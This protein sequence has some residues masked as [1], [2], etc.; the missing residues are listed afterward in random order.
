MSLVIPSNVT[1]IG[2]S[3]YFNS[4]ANSK[5]NPVAE[6][7]GN[8]GIISEF[9]KVVNYSTLMAESNPIYIHFQVCLTI[10]STKAD[11]KPANFVNVRSWKPYVKNDQG[12]YEGIAW[13]TVYSTT[14]C[15]YNLICRSFIIRLGVKDEGNKK[16]NFI[17]ANGVALDLDNDSNVTVDQTLNLLL[18]ANIDPYVIHYSPSG[19]SQNNKLR[20]IIL[21]DKLESDYGRLT[22][23]IRGLNSLLPNAACQVHDPGRFFYTTFLEVPYYSSDS[24]NNFDSTYNHLESIGAITN[25]EA[26]NKATLESFKESVQIQ[27]STD[28]ETSRDTANKQFVDYLQTQI[29]KDDQTIFDLIPEWCKYHELNLDN[30]AVHDSSGDNLEQWRGLDPIDPDGSTTG[31]SFTVYHAADNTYGYNSGRSG[32][33]G[34]M[35]DLWLRLQNQSWTINGGIKD[36]PLWWQSIRD[37]CEYHKVPDFSV[38]YERKQITSKPS[39]DY[40]I[41]QEKWLKGKIVLVSHKCF[42]LFTQTHVGKFYHIAGDHEYWFYCDK[43]CYWKM[44]NFKSLVEEITAYLETFGS[45]CNTPV[46]DLFTASFL[47]GLK[48]CAGVMKKVNAINEFP[49]NYNYVPCANGAYDVWNNEL[50][51]YSSEIKNQSKSKFDYHPSTGKGIKA[52]RDFLNYIAVDKESVEDVLKWIAA[53]VQYHGYDTMKALSI[54]GDP[55]AGKT[56]LTLLLTELMSLEDTRSMVVKK[57]NAGALLDTSQR[58]ETQVLDGC[59]LG[60]F[61]EFAGITDNRDPEKIKDLIATKE[62]KGTL[63]AME[64]KGGRHYYRYVRTAILSNSQ[65]YPRLKNHDDGGWFRRFMTF[66]VRLN[67]TRNDRIF[68]DLNL[69]LHDFFCWCLEQDLT[70]I[71]AHFAEIARVNKNDDNWINRS[72]MEVKAGSNKYWQ[73][74]DDCIVK[75]LESNVSAAVVFKEYLEYCNN[76]TNE[77][78]GTQ[79]SFGKSF[80]KV[81]N[82]KFGLTSDCKVRKTNG[83]YYYG[84]AINTDRG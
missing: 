20:A 25:L 50:V 61:E 24:L 65:D 53:T 56:T 83:Q 63:T 17:G 27:V 40:C 21:F 4:R 18:D 35:P 3:Y 51:P 46:K 28:E 59:L 81:L 23:Y 15:L 10:K 49:I 58:F 80:I 33:S 26:E 47:S 84:I 68:S 71:I 72:N 69:Y 22:H 12:L 32:V 45:V 54:A 82:D 11:P 43:C 74:A 37:I 14:E 38:I 8:T 2:E 30:W 48:V 39:L 44:I 41:D 73:F 77:R 79:T 6:T 78:P 70:E 42:E 36:K 16:T 76:T 57:L 9:E 52:Y 31:N 29:I 34:D 75:D 5:V 19:D 13:H 66:R 60:I 1:R 7:V 62:S 64:R 67:N 55:G